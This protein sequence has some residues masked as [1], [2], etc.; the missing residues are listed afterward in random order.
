MLRRMLHLPAGGG[1]YG[2]KTANESNCRTMEMFGF[3]IWIWHRPYSLFTDICMCVQFQA[4]H[5]CSL[6]CSN[7]HTECLQDVKIAAQ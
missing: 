6:I 1:V 3:L 5:D 4:L 2:D 7:I